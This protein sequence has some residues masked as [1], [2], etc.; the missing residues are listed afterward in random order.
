MELIQKLEKWKEE[1]DKRDWQL[2]SF[3]TDFHFHSIFTLDFHLEKVSEGGRLI[4][5]SLEE[6]EQ[7]FDEYLTEGN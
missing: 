6:L 1:H 5:E 3:R 7:K 2:T 4:A